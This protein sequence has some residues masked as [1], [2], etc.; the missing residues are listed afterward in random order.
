MPDNYYSELNENGVVTPLRDLAAFPRSEQAVLGAKNLLKYPYHNTTKTDKGITFTDNGNGSIT[1]S[2][3]ND[4]TGISNFNFCTENT[5]G[6]RDYL[7]SLGEV[8][9]SGG[10]SNDIF[11][12]ANYYDGTHFAYDKGNGATFTFTNEN[13]GFQI[14]I[15]VVENTDLTTPVTLYPMLRLA[16]DPNSTYA[17]PAMTNLQLTNKVHQLVHRVVYKSSDEG[18]STLT[19]AA[20]EFADISIPSLTGYRILTA[21]VAI[22]GAGSSVNAYVSGAGGS[23][24]R[25][26]VNRGSQSYT[27]G[28]EVEVFYI[29]TDEID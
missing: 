9:L 29:A 8:I 15:N 13:S 3:I 22:T 27:W 24:V 23:N 28:Y 1:L 16:S 12:S 14:C 21:N 6:M 11:L 25:R 26:I 17:P 20:N 5:V 7:L 19:I 4:G 2:G 10:L 18:R